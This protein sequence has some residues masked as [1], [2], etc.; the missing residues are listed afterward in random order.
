[1]YD[2]TALQAGKNE[3][4][5]LTVEKNKQFVRE[6]HMVDQVAFLISLF[7]SG[8]SCSLVASELWGVVCRLDPRKSPS[9]VC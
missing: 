2:E 3:R 4:N 8:S 1:V 6:S 7:L 9:S 5:K